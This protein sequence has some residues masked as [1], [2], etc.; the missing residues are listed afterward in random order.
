M[1]EIIQLLRENN[2]MLRFLCK[3][4]IEK[5]KIQDYKDFISNVAADMYVES[6]TRGK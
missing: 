5:D 3:N 1:E 4:T 6:L 2:I